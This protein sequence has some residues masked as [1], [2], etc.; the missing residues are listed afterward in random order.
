MKM[1]DLTGQKFGRL[2][3]Q[4]KNGKS[5][6]GHYFW[7]CL[8][9]CGKETDVPSSY[10]TSGNTKSCGCLQRDKAREAQTKH[11]FLTKGR[12]KEP[13][14]T[15]WQG[16]KARCNQK[17]FKEYHRYGGRGIKVCPEW[18]KDF[19]VFRQWALENGYEKG[20]EIDRIDVNKGYYPENCRWVKDIVNQRNKSNLIRLEYRGKLLSL[21]EIA[22]EVGLTYHL[23]YQRYHNGWR[24]EKLLQP[25]RERRK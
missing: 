9:D 20:L 13:L 15:T 2:T 16:I 18:E 22:S 17:N 3:V 14:Y 23:I 4:Y 7:H 25:K 24:G 11:G 21:G 5:K 12:P 6:Q 19:S 8:C 1:L 10:L